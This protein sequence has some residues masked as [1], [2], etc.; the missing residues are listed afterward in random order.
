MTRRIGWTV[1]TTSL[2]PV[3]VAASE[4][5]VCRVAFGEGEAELAALLARELPFAT[6]ERD[7]V[8]VRAFA[9]ALARYVDGCAAELA[10][11]LDVAGSRFQQR[12]WAA[13][14]AIPRGEVRSY[15]AV[16]RALGGRRRPAP[17]RAPARR[18]RSRSRS[19]A[20]ASSRATDRSGATTMAWPGNAASSPARAP[21]V[22]ESAPAAR[23]DSHGRAAPAAV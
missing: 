12:V 20:T 1:L 11:P 7:G 2:G 9:D 8:G 18:T 19:P 17:W 13:L 23:G 15:G 21:R 22:A 4:R 10:L 3:L 5:G 16:A 14:R 6:L